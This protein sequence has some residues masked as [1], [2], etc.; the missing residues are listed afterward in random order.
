MFSQ[1]TMETIQQV[2]AEGI[3]IILGGI[4]TEL[5]ILITMLLKKNLKSIKKAVARKVAVEEVKDKKKYS[6]ESTFFRYLK[7]N[8]GEDYGKQSNV[9]NNRFVF[10]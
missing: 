3:I 10:Y 6:F 4:I 1:E 2:Q 7:E 5:V 9:R 8:K